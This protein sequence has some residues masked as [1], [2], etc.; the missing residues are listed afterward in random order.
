MGQAPDELMAQEAAGG[1]AQLQELVTED[2]LLGFLSCS[3][4]CLPYFFLLPL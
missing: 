4:I 3:W 1:G 2:M